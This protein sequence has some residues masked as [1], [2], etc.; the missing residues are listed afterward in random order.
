MGHESD[1]EVWFVRFKN[2]SYSWGTEADSSL[3]H[4]LERA[5]V[6]ATSV[7]FGPH[8]SWLLLE[9]DGYYDSGN[10]PGDLS[11]YCKL[12][13]EEHQGIQTLAMGPDGEYFLKAIDGTF[14]R[15]SLHP[16]LE[17]MLDA[18]TTSG[19]S[20]GWVDR[21]RLGPHGTYCAMFEDYTMWR[22]GT[23]FTMSFL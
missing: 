9:D 14:W 5:D 15:N 4:L 13:D 20:V 18:I 22:A 23:G 6:K 19:S 10:L 2:G 12:A 11:E 3:L 8:N 7:F 16:S 21:I 17:R 1:M